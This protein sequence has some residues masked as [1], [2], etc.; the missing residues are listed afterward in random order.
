MDLNNTPH[1]P[2]MDIPA[3]NYLPFKD[4][5]DL[6]IK[7][8]KLNFIKKLNNNLIKTALEI[9]KIRHS[10]LP[11]GTIIIEPNAIPEA[12]I[13]EI[14]QRLRTMGSNMKQCYLELGIVMTNHQGS[15]EPGALYEGLI[16]ALSNRKN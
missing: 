7:M 8:E 16:N 1:D 15:N 13:E 4:L 6:E 3:I 11:D 14:T 2:G 10:T 12:C 5:A 9:Y